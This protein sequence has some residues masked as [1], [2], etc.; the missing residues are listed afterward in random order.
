MPKKSRVRAHG[1]QAEQQSNTTRALYK[2][3]SI[4]DDAVNNDLKQIYENNTWNLKE[5]F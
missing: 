2:T 1:T 5:V 3:L 4:Q